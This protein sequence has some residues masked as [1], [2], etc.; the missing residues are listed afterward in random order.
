MAEL[1]FLSPNKLFYYSSFAYGK[2]EKETVFLEQ[3]LSFQG[4]TTVACFN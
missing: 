2:K 3:S 1:D 4:A